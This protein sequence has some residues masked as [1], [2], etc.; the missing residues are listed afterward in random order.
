V[1]T[2]KVSYDL[3]MELLHKPPPIE[4]GAVKMIRTEIPN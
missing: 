2:K 4:I 1:H 3:E